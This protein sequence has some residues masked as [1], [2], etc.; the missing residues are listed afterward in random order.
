MNRKVVIFTALLVVA[1][2]YASFGPLIRYLSFYFSD[3]AQVAGRFTIG[4]ILALAFRDSYGGGRP[5]SLHDKHR[6]PWLLAYLIAFPLTV[7]AFTS[8]VQHT[9]I[10]LTV[11]YLYVASCVTSTIFGVLTLQ[12]P[13]TL[14]KCV[15]LSCTVVGIYLATVSSAQPAL[16]SLY[17]TLWA[18][19]AGVFDGLANCSRRALRRLPTQ[20]LL[21]YQLGF[22]AILA[23]L[24]ILTTHHASIKIW[25]P[26]A[27]VVLM[28]LGT[29]TFGVAQSLNICFR[30]VSARVGTQVLAAEIPFA[31]IIAAA[32]FDEIPFLT[33]LIG[34]LIVFLGVI[35]ARDEADVKHT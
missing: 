26:I 2:T 10:A 30:H 28:L 23:T 12:D 31:V 4:T 16:G 27:A 3:Y 32:V 13:V 18:L 24:L 14:R 25:S 22:G 34:G 5:L 7:V 19:F 11:L 1:A 33:Q 6:L 17:P 21:P 15:S 20:A 29:L 35:L 9:T 8:A